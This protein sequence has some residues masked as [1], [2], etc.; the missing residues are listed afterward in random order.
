VTF[1]GL[2]VRGDKSKLDGIGWYFGDYLVQG[3]IIRNADIQGMRVGIEVPVK[4]GTSATEMNTFLIED[5]Y[6]RN[7]FNIQITTM[8]AVEGGGAN[9]AARR[10]VIRNVTFATIN[11]PLPVKDNSGNIVPQYAINMSFLPRPS[12]PGNWIQTDTVEVYD[13]NGNSSDDFRVY[14]H[15]QAADYI[16][17]VTGDGHIGAPVAG[18]TN[19]EAWNLYGIAIAGGVAPSNCIVRP[20]V[21]GLVS[22]L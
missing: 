5:S 8:W 9:M 17:P 18:L 1:D 12:A 19:Q 14:Y 11:N 3:G 15:E 7:Y 6:L 4:V 2:I 21:N 16:V 13:F 10:T 22:P 20:D